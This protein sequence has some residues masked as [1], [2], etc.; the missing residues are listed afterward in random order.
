MEQV[1]RIFFIIDGEFMNPAKIPKPGQCLAALGPRMLTA[2]LDGLRWDDHANRLADDLLGGVAEHA[3]GRAVQ[4]VM[5]PFRSLL[6]I[7]SSDHSNHSG[8]MAAGDVIDRLIHRGT[9]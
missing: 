3:F 5:V 2:R 1:E 7:A 8:E 4:D 9:D 6:M